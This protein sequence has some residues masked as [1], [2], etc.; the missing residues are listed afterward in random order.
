M[1]YKNDMTRMGHLVRAGIFVLITIVLLA[2]PLLSSH[3]LNLKSLL[4]FS[5]GAYSLR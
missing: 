5:P 4:I 2:S 3:S 1:T